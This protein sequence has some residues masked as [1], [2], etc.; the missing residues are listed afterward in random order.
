MQNSLKESRLALSL[1]QRCGQ[2][3]VLSVI[4]TGQSVSVPSTRLSRY[5]SSSCSLFTASAD[6]LGPPLK[7]TSTTLI[8][9][10]LPCKHTQREREMMMMNE[11]MNEWMNETEKIRRS[12]NY[13]VKLIPLHGREKAVPPA[14]DS[15]IYRSQCPG[16]GF[17]SYPFIPFLYSKIFLILLYSQPWLRQVSSNQV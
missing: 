8:L 13:V 4:V 6:T 17:Y 16:A 1:M 10:L 3:C 2:Q 11:W 12:A 9:S 7:H 5:L 14:W 15:G